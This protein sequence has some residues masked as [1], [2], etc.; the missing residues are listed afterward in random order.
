MAV[1]SSQMK[2]KKTFH[3]ACDTDVISIIVYE[4]LDNEQGSTF[5]WPCAMLLS[6]YLMSKKGRVEV[7]SK[8]VLE[9]G[10]GAALP[11]IAASLCRA[12][13][14]CITDREGEPELYSVVQ[15]T[16]KVNG[17]EDVCRHFSL[18]W[19]RPLDASITCDLILGADIL[20]NEEDFEPVLTTINCLLERNSG[21]SALVAY[22]NRRYSTYCH[23][24]IELLTYSDK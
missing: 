18:D 8:S 7:E 9:L 24:V 6:S 1:K 2:V 16:V 22:Q 20:Y 4:S 17:V 15:E 3:I 5:V 11:S 23:S 21:S 14:V 10:A 12:R 19:N 13:N